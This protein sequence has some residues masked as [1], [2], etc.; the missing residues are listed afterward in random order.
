MRA[1]T[2]HSPFCLTRATIDLEDGTVA[3]SLKSTGNQAF[4]DS[5]SSR[6]NVDDS[7]YGHNLWRLCLIFR[8]RWG[9]HTNHLQEVPEE[10]WASCSKGNLWTEVQLKRIRKS[11][12]DMWGH[13]H[14]SIRTEWD[15]TLA[16]DHNFFEMWKMMV[17]TDQLLHITE[18]TGSKLYTT[19]LEDET[20]GRARNL[21]LSLKQCHAHYYW[22]YEK[23]KTRAR[24]DL[25]GLH[26]SNAFWCCNVSASVGLKS[27]C[28]CCFTL[29]ATM[30]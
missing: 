10:V 12:Q 8:H 9:G 22:F 23:R 11:H 18:A 25:Q 1:G 17:R 21:V 7:H 19:E 28:P 20:H 27:F 4:S 2:C 26:T 6:E 13:D 14:K 3:Q 24:L 29:G 30:K 5:E 16:E 15:H